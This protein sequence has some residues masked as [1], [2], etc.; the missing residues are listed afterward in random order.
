M[1]VRRISPV[2]EAFQFSF[3]VWQIAQ[4]N[5]KFADEIYQRIE[6]VG[7][8]GTPCIC[9]IPLMDGDYVIYQADGTLHYV[10]R[11]QE[12]AQKFEVIER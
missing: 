5:P 4:G 11:R 6:A 9:G 3:D 12:F 10:V 1:K 2:Y 8:R 7:S